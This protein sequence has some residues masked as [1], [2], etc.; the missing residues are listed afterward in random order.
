MDFSQK[1]KSLER[2]LDIGEYTI[3]AKECL[4]LI[5]QALR[6]LFTQHLTRLDEKDRLKVL[7]VERNVGKGQK[8]IESFT[9]G[10]LVGVFRASKF[11]DAWARSTG[12][13]LRSIRA[14][15][16]DE[17]TSLRNAFIHEEQEATRSEAEFLIHCLKVFLETFGVTQF[18]ASGESELIREK[19]DAASNRRGEVPGPPPRPVVL[20][21]SGQGANRDQPEPLVLISSVQPADGFARE[22]PQEWGRA[23]LDALLQLLKPKL[24]Q[25]LSSTIALDEIEINTETIDAHLIEALERTPIL[26]ILLSQ[27]YLNSAWCDRAQH[28][29]LRLVQERAQKDASVFTLWLDEL[30]EKEV[31]P[32]LLA[33]TSHRYDLW[34]QQ[35]YHSLL[36]EL[37]YDLAHALQEYQRRRQAMENS[38]TLST[39]SNERQCVFLADVTDD[40][41][42]VREELEHLLVQAD[43]QVLPEDPLAY[44]RKAEAFQQAVRE[45]LA[46]C[47]L[48][49]QLLSDLP[50]RR[51]RNLPQGYA[52]CQY[53]IAQELRKPILQWR[54]PDLELDAVSDRNQAEFLSLETVH[55]ID[56]QAFHAKIL[57]AIAPARPPAG[58]PDGLE[59]LGVLLFLNTNDHEDK[60]LVARICQIFDQFHVGYTLPLQSP[61]PAENRKAFEQYVLECSGL[62]IV[63]GDVSVKWVSDQLLE[64]RKIFWKRPQPLMFAVVDGPPS[65][66]PPV[67]FRLPNMRILQCRDCIDETKL[68]EFIKLLE[69]DRGK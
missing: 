21:L 1:M 18:E 58:A 6:Q 40:L 19:L 63:Y 5:E 30:P 3:A 15:N 47:D 53:E 67:N 56:V 25:D 12:S 20:A 49:V 68:W 24:P 42:A 55:A 33:V 38:P 17:L 39:S 29:F 14:I 31:P 50:G 62:V 37:S 64:I 46:Q 44:P 51:P 28:H 13:E 4:G 9:M 52:R 59:H 8:G 41:D 54:S 65:E 61:K 35:R 48:F 57:T 43:I 26:I 66:K 45:D 32:E 7:D 34:E 27:A 16:L 60:S 36:N 10:Q 11:L 23:A 2:L 22:G 69:Q